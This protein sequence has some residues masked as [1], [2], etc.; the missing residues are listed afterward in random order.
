MPSSQSM[1]PFFFSL[2]D[3]LTTVIFPLLSGTP[4]CAPGRTKLCLAKP[5]P[6]STG[7]TTTSSGRCPRKMA[8]ASATLSSTKSPNLVLSVFF[9]LCFILLCFF[10]YASLCFYLCSFTVIGRCGRGCILFVRFYKVF[11]DRKLR[12]DD[13]EML[14]ELCIPLFRV[15]VL[16]SIW[17]A[18]MNTNSFITLP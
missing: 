8:T 9:P 14:L 2:F 3:N 6:N 12:Y 18:K 4:W 13:Q 16:V 15:R 1:D 7:W 11:E 17:K 10:S 5:H